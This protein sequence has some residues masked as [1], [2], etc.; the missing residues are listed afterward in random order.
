MKV[1]H[2]MRFFKKGI[3]IGNIPAQV[4]LLHSAHHT[5]TNQSHQT[6]GLRSALPNVGSAKAHFVAQ[7]VIL[8]G[9]VLQLKGD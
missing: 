7:R 6:Y 5:T 9:G 8:L 4:S 3:F 1:R 2:E